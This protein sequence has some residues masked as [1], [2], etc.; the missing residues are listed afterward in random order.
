VRGGESLGDWRWEV[1]TSSHPGRE[2]LDISL[3]LLEAERLRRALLRLRGR[4]GEGSSVERLLKSLDLLERGLDAY[5]R[6][7]S[8]LRSALKVAASTRLTE[9]QLLLLRWIAEE[10]SGEV[11][12]VL[13]ERA[14][15][16]LGI[17]KSTVR[18]NMRRLREGGL[19][20]A[21]DRENKGVPVRVTEE[22]LTLLTL[23]E[24]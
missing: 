22:G 12:T 4:V 8:T 15:R 18:W 23:L 14:S 16:E 7:M 2:S 24:P 5:L 9:K 19:I 3:L 20:E 21:G 11:Y 13:I 10:S 17:P 1:A 6:E